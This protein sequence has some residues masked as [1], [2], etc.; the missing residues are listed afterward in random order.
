MVSKCANPSCTASFRYWHEG[1]LY[2]VEIGPAQDKA[3]FTTDAESRRSEFF[4]LCE[5]CSAQMTLEY[6]PGQGITLKPSVQA[7][8]AAS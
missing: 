8:R 7:L 5:R 4:W 3:R 6:H 2:R 1:K